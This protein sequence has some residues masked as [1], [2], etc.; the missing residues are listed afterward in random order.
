[1]KSN[2]KEAD[3]IQ[4]PPKVAVK[5]ANAV[6]V[7]GILFSILVIIYAIY[8][9]YN[10]I[11]D[12][13]LGNIHTR[14]Y[15]LFCI[16]LG[17][18][19]ATLFGLGLRLKNSLKVNLSVLFVTTGISVCTF[20]TYLEILRR[21]MLKQTNC[22]YYK[23]DSTLSL[24]KQEIAKD[25]GIPYDTRTKLEVLQDL[26]KDGV[27]A[28]PNV[29]PRSIS[30]NK[31]TIYTLGG[32][33]NITTI[34][35]NESGYFPIIEFDEHG[36]NNP[37]GLYKKNRVDIVLTGDSMTEGFSVHSN[38]NIGAVLRKSGFNVISVG[39][40]GNDSLTELAA[41]KEYAEPLR[42]KIVF[43]VYYVNDLDHLGSEMDSPLLRKYL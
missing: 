26:R 6:F 4:D 39:K 11:Y 34:F 10:P 2:S 3:R 27:E 7:L 38:E 43:W 32:I 37:K 20:E 8:R 28:Y 25:M 33:S 1:M 23:F 36:F 16:L 21:Q 9:I 14:K 19:F 42:P 29:G 12:A 5:I 31:G 30:T 40:G 13:H 17:G 35:G 41:I 24:P 22:I 15:Y 18:T